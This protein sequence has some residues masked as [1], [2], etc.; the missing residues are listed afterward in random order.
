VPDPA[1]KWPKDLIGRNF[2]PCSDLDQCHVGDITYIRTQ[3]GWAY[4]ATVIDLASRRVLGWALADHMRTELVEDALKMALITSLG[5]PGRAVLG[6]VLLHR[7]LVQHKAPA[8]L[9]RLHEPR[10]IRGVNREQYRL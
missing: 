8:Q 2:A 7:G 3:E 6:G 4:L 1:G 9:T 5:H 10:R